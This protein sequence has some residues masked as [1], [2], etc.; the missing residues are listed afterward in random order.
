ML[1]KVSKNQ[2]VWKGLENNDKGIRDASGTDDNGDADGD[3][4]ADPT[5]EKSN[6]RLDEK[7]EELRQLQ[8]E[9][10]E[11]DMMIEK[12]KLHNDALR[13][14]DGNGDG[15]IP[16]RTS[17]ARQ[18]MSIKGCSMGPI[19]SVFPVCLFKTGR[20]RRAAP[21]NRKRPG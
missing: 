15:V 6:E 7:Q 8:N 13:N 4:D 12:F 9:T 17:S 21:V 1:Q 19:I 14:G 20:T 11:L 3:G 16:S 18:A 10:M 2:I 5:A